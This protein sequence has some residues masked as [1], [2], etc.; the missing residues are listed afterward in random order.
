LSTWCQR[1]G[2]PDADFLPGLDRSVDD[3]H[4]RDDANVTVVPGVDDQ[5][6]QR[7]L[8]IASRRRHAPDQFFKKLRD[9]FAGLRADA[10]RV[11]GFDPDD[12]LDLRDH[13]FGI[14]RRQ[15]DLVQ[16][17]HDLETLLERRIAIGHALRLDALRSIDDEQRALAGGQERETRTRSPRALA[18]RSC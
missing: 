18:C 7:R 8:G 10:N 15:V 4:E 16:H 12:L 14:G 13:L 6:L 3:A 2:R 1:T 11:S 5:R 17:R 9:V